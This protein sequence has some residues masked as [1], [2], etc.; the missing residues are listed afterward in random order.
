MRYLIFIL[1]IYSCGKVPERNHSEYATVD[2]D[3]KESGTEAAKA[4]ENEN[5][6]LNAVQDKIKEIRSSFDAARNEKDFF[7]EANKMLEEKTGILDQQI[8]ENNEITKN[9]LNEYNQSSEEMLKRIQNLEEK[10]VSLE[11]QND[12]HKQQIDKLSYNLSRS[13]CEIKG[14]EYRWMEENRQ[15]EK[16]SDLKVKEYKLVPFAGTGDFNDSES[17]RFQ[18]ESGVL[19]GLEIEIVDGDILGFHGF[20]SKGIATRVFDDGFVSGNN[21]TECDGSRMEEFEVVFQGDHLSQ[22]S[23]R[24]QNSDSMGKNFGQKDQHIS[25]EVSRRLCDPEEKPA[26]LEYKTDPESGAVR[27]VAWVCGSY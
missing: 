14:T 19:T 18:C 15:C 1:I 4:G 5:K 26:G 2:G 3:S 17:H 21:R 6:D 7:V 12:H 25:Q 11:N 24:C 23:F 9:Q 16:V 27:S 8:A 20:C 10:N 13:E 22:I